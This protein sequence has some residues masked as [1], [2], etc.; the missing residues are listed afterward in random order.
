VAINDAGLAHCGDVGK[1]LEPP[2]S[3][4][5]KKFEILGEVRSER[6]WEMHEAETWKCVRTPMKRKISVRQ[7]TK[8]KLDDCD[9]SVFSIRKSSVGTQR[10]DQSLAM[11]CTSMTRQSV[12]SS[13]P[14]GNREEMTLDRSVARKLDFSELQ[15]PGMSHPKFG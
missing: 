9:L 12:Q 3:P 7:S 6:E 2:P 13:E 1:N 4:S 11:I 5:S 8:S 14:R 15:R 10:L